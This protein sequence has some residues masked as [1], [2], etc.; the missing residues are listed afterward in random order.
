MQRRKLRAKKC[1]VCI[2]DSAS[3]RAQSKSKFEK[4]FFKLMNNSIYGKTCEN[5]LVR[6]PIP[7]AN[8]SYWD[9]YSEKNSLS[10]I[11]GSTQKADKQI[12][13]HQSQ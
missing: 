2:I 8:I 11:A 12:G 9:C 6:Q 7:I 13:F 3:M 5:R 10:T 4:D 1:M